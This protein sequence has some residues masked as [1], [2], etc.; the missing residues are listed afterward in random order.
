MPDIK[1][2]DMTEDTTPPEDA[3]VWGQHADGSADIRVPFKSFKLIGKYATGAWPNTQSI[4]NGGTRSWISWSTGSSS[5][6]DS[7]SPTRLTVPSGYDGVYIGLWSLTWN[8]GGTGNR[9]SSI[10]RNR[11]GFS[12]NYIYATAPGTGSAWMTQMG[13]TLPF[14]MVAGDYVE[15]EC[16]QT[17][18]GSI[19]VQLSA[20][21]SFLSLIRIG[22]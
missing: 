13:W 3:V 18:S 11:S 4:S 17:S 19:S 8:T 14:G 2:S 9:V 20:D 6:W 5:W 16:S 1:P 7:G 22:A 15:L 21:L 12:Q 10:E